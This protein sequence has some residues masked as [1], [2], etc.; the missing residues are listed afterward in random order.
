MSFGGVWHL[1]GHLAGVGNGASGGGAAALALTVAEAVEL[2]GCDVVATVGW[3]VVA[4]GAGGVLLRSVAAGA[5]A[6]GNVNSSV[7]STKPTFASRVI[8]AESIA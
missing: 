2:T 5:H 3:V 6:G 8:A 4:G 1:L 7:A